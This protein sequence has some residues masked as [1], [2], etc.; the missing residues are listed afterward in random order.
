VTTRFIYKVIRRLLFRSRLRGSRCLTLDGPVIM[1]ANH[2]GS[3]GPVSIITT[4]PLKAYPWV[5]HEVTEP[6]S[7]ARRVQAEFLEQELHLR[8]PVSEFLGR[9]VGRICAALMRDI[10]AIPVYAKSRMIAQTLQLSLRLL[11]EGKNILVFA[12]DTMRPLN[13]S[14]C[15][16]CTGFI[17]LAR[18]YYE[19][20]RKAIQFVPVAVNRKARAIRVGIPIRFDA[21]CPFPREKARLKRELESS[22]ASLWRELE[23]RAA[24]QGASGIV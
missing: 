5:T 23:G 3:F 2:A 19:R 6:D 10:G 24:V 13:E 20:T 18:L 21:H 16:F 14:I 1:V 17:H 11:E 12:E 4:V 8:P 15:E 9:I 22:V 7:A